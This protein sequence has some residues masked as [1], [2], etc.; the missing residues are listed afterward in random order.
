MPSGARHRFGWPRPALL[1]ARQRDEEGS[2]DSKAASPLAGPPALCCRIC[3]PRLSRSWQPSVLLVAD[4][5]VWRTSLDVFFLPGPAFILYSGG[6]RNYVQYCSNCGW[7]FTER[8]SRV[9]RYCP[10]CGC[11][12]S[13]E[14]PVEVAHEE[15]SVSFAGEAQ[16]HLLALIPEYGESHDIA[17]GLLGT[18]VGTGVAALGLKAAVWG[19]WLFVGGLIFGVASSLIELFAPLPDSRDRRSH[20]RSKGTDLEGLVVGGAIS[21]AGLWLGITGLRFLGVGLF[22]ALGS[23]VVAGRGI[24]RELKKLYGAYKERRLREQAGR[25]IDAEFTIRP[26]QKNAAGSPSCTLPVPLSPTSS[27]ARGSSRSDPAPTRKS[28]RRSKRRKTGRSCGRRKT[29]T[30]RNV[31]RSY[32]RGRTGRRNRV[33]RARSRRGTARSVA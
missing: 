11:H 6:M 18:A 26:S 19:G 22:T 23:A 28:R 17:K 27:S 25:V 1:V 2:G 9:S 31:A 12:A 15:S 5:H 29:S 21:S 3:R 16:Q 4:P 30:R 33:R 20:N 14:R 7:G 13:R 24:Y 8:Q 10:R 32:S